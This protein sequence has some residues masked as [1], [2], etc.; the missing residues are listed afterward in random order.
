[1]KNKDL[2]FFVVI[3]IL[4]VGV[5]YFFTYDTNEGKTYTSKETLC[6]QFAQ[7]Y[8]KTIPKV[9]PDFNDEKWQMAVDVETDFYNMCLLD[10]NKD[11]LKNYNPR[12][13]EKY[14]K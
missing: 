3:A 4:I 14:K 13:I 11:A 10:L 5:T 8:L 6:I 9:E 1:M 12:A 7:S 2:I